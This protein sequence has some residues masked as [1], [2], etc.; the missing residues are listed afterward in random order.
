MGHEGWRRFR[1]DGIGVELDVPPGWAAVRDALGCAVIL[2][3]L[4]DDREVFRSS[5]NVTVEVGDSIDLD[6]L[7]EVQ[8]AASARALT[9]MKVDSVE[10]NEIANRPARHVVAGYREGETDIRLEQWLIDA[11]IGAIALTGTLSS[12]RRAEIGPILEEVVR[13][14]SLLGGDEH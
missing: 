12:D 2:L 11:P 14:F 9:A 6:E 10:S 5:I 7:I 3:E 8:T 13:G 1:H 4:R